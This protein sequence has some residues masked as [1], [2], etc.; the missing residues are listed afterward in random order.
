MHTL[1]CTYTHVLAAG[2]NNIQREL[3]CNLHN[4]AV[5][6]LQAKNCVAVTPKKA[7]SN[8]L[9]PSNYCC[10]SGAEGAAV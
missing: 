3:C 10:L 9:Y 4:L 2:E 5:Q 8:N 6:T 7:T 1:T